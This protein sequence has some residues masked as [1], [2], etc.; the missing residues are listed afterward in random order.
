VKG[1]LRP[2]ST[3]VVSD[4]LGHTSSMVSDLGKDRTVILIAW[5]VASGSSLTTGWL[6]LLSVQIVFGLIL[7]VF[8]KT[9]LISD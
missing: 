2:K 4:I 5:A 7:F 1:N 9:G 8:R 6:G 3:G